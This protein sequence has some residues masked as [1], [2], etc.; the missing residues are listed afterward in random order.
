MIPLITH[1]H[2]YNDVC[3]ISSKLLRFAIV[4][5]TCIN[6]LTY[7]VYSICVKIANVKSSTSSCI[8]DNNC[9]LQFCNVLLIIYILLYDVSHFV[10]VFATFST[11]LLAAAVFDSNDCNIYCNLILYNKIFLYDSYICNLKLQRFSILLK[12]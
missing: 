9:K 11:T 3:T 8:F 12:I 10:K 1:H 6:S 5:S 2:I 4:F 7:I